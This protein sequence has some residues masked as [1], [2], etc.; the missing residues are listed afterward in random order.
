MG[1]DTLNQQCR[2]AYAISDNAERTAAVILALSK[3]ES[4]ERQAMDSA[5]RL[6]PHHNRLEEA[7]EA[8]NVFVNA[9]EYIRL[10]CF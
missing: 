10:R 9:I 7:M 8:A 1:A 6:R 5:E 4:M 3:A 2:D